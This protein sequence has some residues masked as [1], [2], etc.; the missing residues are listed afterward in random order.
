[1]LPGDLL[2]CVVTGS[3]IDAAG[4]KL[5]GKVTFTPSVLLTDATGTT[6]IDGTRTCQLSG[7]SFTSP[8][9][10]AT[11]NEDIAQDGWVYEVCVALENAQPVTYSLPIPHEPSPVDLSALIAAAA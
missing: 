1:M 2:T 4:Q 10:V 7:G 8:P 3:F 9:L 5:R 6:V 11:D